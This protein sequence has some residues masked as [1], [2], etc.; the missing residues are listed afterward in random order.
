MAQESLFRSSI[1]RKFSMALSAFFLL[2]FLLM[3]FTSNLMS[4]ISADAFN[5]ISHFL[6]YNPLIQYL[7]QPI[8]IFAIIYHF[9]MG[10]ILEIQNKKARPVRYAKNSPAANSSWA[11]RNMIWSGAVILAFLVLH[12]IDFWFPEMN[13]KYVEANPEDATRYYDELLH[14]FSNPLR[15][16]AYVI[17]FFLLMMHLL[18]GFQSAF[19]SVGA[20]HKKY[21]P[22]IK[23]FGKVFAIVIPVGFMLIAIINYLKTI[24]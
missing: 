8:L 17:A 13:Y 5:S 24:Q 11:S 15:V 14:R 1:G 10:V 6:G 21:T 7:I 12:M 19:Q 2:I 16:G 22:F 18:H 20:N 3:H 9:I 4:I 23:T